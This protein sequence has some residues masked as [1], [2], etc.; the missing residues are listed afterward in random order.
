MDILD[1]SLGEKRSRRK[2]NAPQRRH[3]LDHSPSGIEE[4]QSDASP[5]DVT[6][7]LNKTPLKGAGETKMV[8]LDEL[9]QINQRGLYDEKETP[10][11]LEQGNSAR[12]FASSPYES[13]DKQSVEKDSNDNVTPSPRSLNENVLDQP[14]HSYHGNYNANSNNNNTINISLTRF[15]QLPNTTA[16]SYSNSDPI[17]NLAAFQDRFSALSASMPQSVLRGAI[18]APLTTSYGSYDVQ[19]ID[20]PGIPERTKKQNRWAFNVWREWAR[21]RNLSVSS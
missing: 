14:P 2:T 16:G 5:D 7:A 17:S 18:K 8:A 19:P 4:E 13:E 20:A 11:E 21:K 9:K 1:L 12:S 6:D 10:Q 3:G 15:P